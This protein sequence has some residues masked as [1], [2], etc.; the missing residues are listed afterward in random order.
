MTDLEKE[1][2]QWSAEAQNN[3]KNMLNK[4]IVDSK[5]EKEIE[6]VSA[7][8]QMKLMEILKK[9]MLIKL[10]GKMIFVE[11]SITNLV[12]CVKLK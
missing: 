11:I 8:A 4:P 10:A 7:K 6:E 12:F 5:Q 2:S 9:A 3:V 1:M